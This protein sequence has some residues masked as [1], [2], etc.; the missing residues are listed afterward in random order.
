MLRGD[1]YWSGITSEVDMP[2]RASLVVVRAAQGEWD[3][4]V[5]FCPA[6]DGPRL[7]LP[8]PAVDILI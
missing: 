5:E 4:Y 2:P 1:S 3:L 6:T 8:A 7:E